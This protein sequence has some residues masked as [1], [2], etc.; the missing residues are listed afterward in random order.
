L[1][2]VPK[3]ELG[4][5]GNLEILASSLLQKIS[6]PDLLRNTLPSGN[7]R[8]VHKRTSSAWLD[9]WTAL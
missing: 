8:C 7:R 4:N 2:L 6:Y 1:L 9:R 5:E 3:L